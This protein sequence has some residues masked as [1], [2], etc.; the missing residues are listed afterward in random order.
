MNSHPDNARPH[1]V[2]HAEIGEESWREVAGAQLTARPNHS[3]F[4]DLASCISP[5]L[6]SLMDLANVL[7]HQVSTYG[8]G[9]PVYDDTRTVDP[10]VRLAEAAEHLR[11]MRDALA[12]ARDHAEG[13]WSEI[14]HIGVEVAP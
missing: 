10:A 8:D 11:A 4:Y 2:R 13:F 9:R 5:T 14:A 3:D 1:V 6:Y 12:V 7:A